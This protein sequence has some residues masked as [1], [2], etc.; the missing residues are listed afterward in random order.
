MLLTKRQKSQ[1]NQNL[2]IYLSVL[3]IYPTIPNDNNEQPIMIVRNKLKE[4][5]Y[6]VL[7]S[8]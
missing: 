6:T 4:S 1:R 7:L 2:K 5:L 3:L 8:K